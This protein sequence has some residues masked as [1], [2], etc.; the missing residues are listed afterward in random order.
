MNI[1]TPRPSFQHPAF[2]LLYLVVLLGIAAAIVNVTFVQRLF[3]LSVPR[4]EY[5]ENIPAPVQSTS[6][7]L[8]RMTL[9]AAQQQLAFPIPTFGWV[10]AGYKVGGAHVSPP[11]WANVYYLPTAPSADASYAGFAIQVTR[12]HDTSEQVILGTLAQEA[13]TVHGQPAT[14]MA[15]DAAGMLRWEANGFSYNLSYSDM[16]L[17]RE[18]VQRLA[19]SLR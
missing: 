5:T 13:I 11:D 1:S 4:I 19:E 7:E 18:D 17:S 8:P 14:Y 9:D 3:G 2:V 10:P 15:S 16:N 6:R 12:G